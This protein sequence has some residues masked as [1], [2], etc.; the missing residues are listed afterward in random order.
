MR[1]T[2]HSFNKI[3]DYKEEI[4]VLIDNIND[5]DVFRHINVDLPDNFLSNLQLAQIQRL[6]KL[7]Q[8]LQNDEPELTE[9]QET[10]KLFIDDLDQKEVY[11]F[12]L[13]NPFLINEEELSKLL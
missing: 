4:F 13:L 7:K 12:S 2:A 5:I 10:L 3:L 1:K 9:V 6:T 8:E 11:E